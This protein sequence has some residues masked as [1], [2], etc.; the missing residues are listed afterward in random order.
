MSPR[1]QCV[2]NQKALITRRKT[3]LAWIMQYRDD[4]KPSNQLSKLSKLRLATNFT[5]PFLFLTYW[6]PSI[7][8]PIESPP[9]RI[10]FRLWLLKFP[11]SFT[12]SQVCVCG[13]GMCL[14][15]LYQWNER[16]GK[17]RWRTW[18]FSKKKLS[19]FIQR[20]FLHTLGTLK[21]S[22][23]WSILIWSPLLHLTIVCM[24]VLAE[25]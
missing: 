11:F 17:E 19:I 12:H 18:L 3:Q 22:R 13:W 24:C 14:Q 25:K 5:E 4:Y 10:R 2:T 7:K 15:N 20:I 1:T 9:M 23:V 21:V 8:A 6:N 16:D